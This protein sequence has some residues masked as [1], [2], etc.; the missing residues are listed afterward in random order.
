MNNRKEVKRENKQVRKL[1]KLRSLDSKGK[2]STDRYKKLKQKVYNPFIDTRKDMK[3]MGAAMG[4]VK[5]PI[6]KYDPTEGVKKG[7]N[8]SVLKKP[9]HTVIKKNPSPTTGG[10]G[11]RMTAAPHEYFLGGGMAKGSF[12]LAK[13]AIGKAVSKAK[14]FVKNLATD[15]GIDQAL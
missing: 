2:N 3:K 1:K 8:K 14:P 9:L 6:P 4:K 12:N 5:N 13:S 10:Q 15:F 7:V 11:I